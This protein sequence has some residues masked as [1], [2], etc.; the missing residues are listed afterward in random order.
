MSTII[1]QLPKVMPYLLW[2]SFVLSLSSVLSLY[3]KTNCRVK[4][5]KICTA[6]ATVLKRVVIASFIS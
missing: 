2:L 1:P 5:F 3:G 4:S 6:V